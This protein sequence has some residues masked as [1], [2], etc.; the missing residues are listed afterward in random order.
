MSALV[1]R[2]RWELYAK[3]FVR[4]G[5]HGTKAAIAAGFTEAS[6]H[7]TSTRLLKNPKISDRIEE[8]KAVL[9]DKV[10]HLATMSLED[11]IHELECLAKVDIA[12]F[13]DLKTGNL[14]GD[15]EELPRDVRVAIS[16]FE[17]KADA[18]APGG[19]VFKVKF[20]D[21]Q[22]ALVNL[23][24]HLGAFEDKVRIITNILDTE[25]QDVV[26]ARMDAAEDELADA[27]SDELREDEDFG[28]WAT[29]G[30]P[31]GVQ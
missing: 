11:V 7:T 24:R 31:K 12:L 22:A 15:L 17:R 25:P 10:D 21:K 2:P 23:G 4:N 18:K 6:A 5:F 27:L 3:E 9:A 29:V 26:D 28:G 13:V 1:D 20:H 8:L 16:S 14:R 19:Y 30:P